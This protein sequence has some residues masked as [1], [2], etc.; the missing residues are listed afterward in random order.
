MVYSRHSRGHFS[1]LLMVCLRLVAH[2]WH[3]TCHNM[4]SIAYGVD[5]W[6]LKCILSV[7]ISWL[8]CSGLVGIAVFLSENFA[9]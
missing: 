9:I 8:Y 4:V 2:P 6:G 5:R 7:R 3:F 1:P